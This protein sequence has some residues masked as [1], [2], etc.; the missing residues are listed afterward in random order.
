MFQQQNI[1]LA[2]EILFVTSNCQQ[3]NISPKEIV[4]F[5][6]LGYGTITETEVVHYLLLWCQ[7]L[8]YSVLRKFLKFRTRKAADIPEIV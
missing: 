7:R 6:C 2:H 1:E 4:H 5:S 3:L 8:Q